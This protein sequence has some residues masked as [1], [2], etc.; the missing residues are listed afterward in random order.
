[1]SILLT[2]PLEIDIHIRHQGRKCL[3]MSLGWRPQRAVGWPTTGPIWGW[4]HTGWTPKTRTRQHAVLACSR[5]R[6]YHTFDVLAQ[7][8]VD[9][10]DNSKNFIVAFMHFGTEVKLLPD[11]PEAAAHPEM[12][13][14]EDVD[15]GMNPE[16]GNVDEVEDKFC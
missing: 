8:I 12:E 7:A 1:M 5:L 3:K 15:L 13:G 6:G 4:R 14:V 9:T 11:I 2:F 16:A 10:T